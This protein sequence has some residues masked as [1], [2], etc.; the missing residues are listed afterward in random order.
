VLTA[1]ESQVQSAIMSEMMKQMGSESML[2]AVSS[3]IM[4]EVGQGWPFATGIL[5]KSRFCML[6]LH[7]LSYML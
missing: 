7:C 6:M 1:D 2:S 5:K 3:D 4:K